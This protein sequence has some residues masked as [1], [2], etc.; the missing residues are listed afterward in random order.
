M[1][2]FYFGEKARRTSPGGKNDKLRKSAKKPGP[3]ALAGL[4]E[5]FQAKS[6]EIRRLHFSGG[7]GMEV[8]RENTAL[9]DWL[10]ESVFDSV[11][12][13]FG[14]APG[15]AGWTLLAVGGYGRG[16]LNPR[17]DVDIM[18]L[19]GDGRVVDC[20]D[21]LP[22]SA[23][24]MLWDL[25]L[26]L[27]YSVRGVSECA[28]LAAGDYTI[29][30]SLLE[31]RRLC[32]DAALP[33]ELENSL[34]GH[35]KPRMVE[36]Y[37]RQKISDRNT[38]RKKH[39]DSV[40]LREPNIKEGAGGLRDIH[41]A[42]WISRF[43]YGAGT[44]DELVEDGL[45]KRSELK[46]LKGSRDYLLR[47]RNEIHYVSGHKQDVLTFELQERA[48]EDFGYRPRTGRMAVENFMRAYY[49]RARGVHD[50]TQRIIES[51][52][53]RRAVKR[54][55][56][57]P[58]TRKKLDSDFYIMGRALCME[59]GALASIAE[60]PE[61]VMEAFSHH[62]A[63]G[64]P[65]SDNL[66]RALQESAL[67]VRRWTVE[68][69]AAARTFLEMMGRTERLYDT[70]ELMHRMK[71]LGRILPEF[72]SVSALV[73]HDLY[74]KY[75]VDE[76][77]LLAMKKLQALGGADGVAYPEFREALSRVPDKQALM[78]AALLHDTG[79]A[80]GGG[81]SERGAAL[82]RNAAER[83]G[84]AGP[85][86]ELVE[87]LVRNHLLMVHVS[88]RR[89]LSDSVVLEKFC[90]IVGGRERL[91]ML[92]V[93]SY[94]DISAV[95]PGVFN[96]WRR[97]LLGELHGRAAAYLEDK[98]SVVAY[99]NK[100]FEDLSTELK[101]EV[102]AAGLGTGAQVGK[103][104]DN[105]PQR[106]L[107]SVPTG[108]AAEHFRLY[109][110]MNSSDVMIHYEHDQGG[111]TSL[112]IILYDVPGLFYVVAGA[113]AAKNMN[114]L[115]ADI[116]TGRDGVVI[117]TLRVTDFNKQLCD[118]DGLWAE[119]KDT[120]IR[121]LTGRARVRDLMPSGPAYPR[122]TALRKNPPRVVVDNEVSD[123]FTVMEVFA[124]DRIGLL[125][126]ITKT[127]FDLGCYIYSA[128]VDTDVDQVVDVFYVTDIFRMKIYD[129]ERIRVLREA[130]VEAVS[131]R[132]K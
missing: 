10:V 36:D 43:K 124:H 41:S 14:V 82:A 48:A 127:M 13:M 33:A 72:G 5:K 2:L 12:G 78:L 59:D 66:S 50:I 70:L 68:P 95:G 91:D 26:D 44:L 132:K 15:G 105:M 67:L 28:S 40:Y 69:G 63:S 129:P 119:I 47:L 128:R 75:T 114:I 56:F 9:M 46:R 104:L 102:K 92:F 23:L 101:K 126:D 1:P 118:D 80:Q 52:I 116:F 107:L 77:S 88:Q 106:Y 35:R 110:D 6:D 87:F 53:D 84:M 18:F 85:R 112:N 55:F 93:L 73:Q 122:R 109:R 20:P 76:H 16:E 113:L 103:F 130:L 58:P 99:E 100:R 71:L 24:H 81:H 45:L 38:R 25:G 79:K 19:K 51:A 4:R 11:C 49:L 98:G 27:G 125:Y 37:I 17:S 22:T 30:T 64:V 62:Q 89:E 61:L 32:G 21:E 117:D 42:L 121:A 94:A 83:L 57:L 86:A 97:A 3:G 65:F 74:H 31:A 96:Q 29:M 120:L 8:V 39:G 123:R 7:S 54:W 34:V 60:K 111:F 90:R 115:S 131:E 108:A